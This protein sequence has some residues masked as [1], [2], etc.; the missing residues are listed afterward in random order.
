DIVA[1]GG[2][3]P[4]RLA[5]AHVQPEKVDLAWDLYRRFPPDPEI[6]P[7]VQ[8]IQ[9]GRSQLVRDVSDDL[10]RSVTHD[11]EH[12]RIAKELGLVSWMVVPLPGRRRSLGAITFVSS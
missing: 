6:D 12:Y 7:I 8:V 10:L 9:S 11:E 3:P 5:V 2:E 1:R 4:R